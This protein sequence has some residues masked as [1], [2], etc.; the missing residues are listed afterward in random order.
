MRLSI[1][2]SFGQ[3]VPRNLPR[4]R[5][6]RG[7]PLPRLRLRRCRPQASSTSSQAVHC[8]EALDPCGMLLSLG[9]ALGTALA[10]ASN[11]PVR[12]FKQRFEG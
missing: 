7:P 2:I 9:R 6:P 11:A 3:P 8:I 1:G 10:D 12:V 4:I 5:A